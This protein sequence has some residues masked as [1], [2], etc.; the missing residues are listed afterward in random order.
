MIE[1]LHPTRFKLDGE[2]HPLQF[3]DDELELV[4]KTRLY[5]NIEDNPV[6]VLL[7][8]CSFIALNKTYRF[9]SARVTKKFGLHLSPSVFNFI[10]MRDPFLP[11]I[12][13][14]KE[15]LECRL[16]YIPVFS[17]EYRLKELQKALEQAKTI[18]DI[19]LRTKAV[20]EV[21]RAANHM[22]DGKNIKIT[23][24][25]DSQ[26][27]VYHKIVGKIHQEN[28]LL[29]DR[30]PAAFSQVTSRGVKEKVPIYADAKD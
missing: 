6:Q 26:L 10:R 13:R 24:T 21:I 18:E 15:V 19:T 29:P 7:V 20:V 17:K 27:T 14:F 30:N 3:T 9:V 4:R 11:V 25:E 16:Q 1:T 8:I 12:K 22:I 2:N 28:A 5:T 23:K